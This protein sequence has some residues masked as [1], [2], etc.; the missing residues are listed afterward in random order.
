MQV[1]TIEGGGGLRLHVR[2]WGDPQGAAILLVHGWSQSHMSW[3]HQFDSTLA[4]EFRLVALDLRGHGM[5]EKPPEA[6]HYTDERLWAD[7]IAAVTGGLSLDRPVLVGW[8]Y[9]FIVSDYVRAHGEGS[10]SGINYVDAAVMLTEAFDH[11]GPGFLENAQ[12]A[13]AEDLPTNIAAMRRFLRACTAEPLGAEEREKA[14]CYNMVVSS[15]VRGAMI[16]RRLDSD[17]VL[18]RMTLPVLMTHG[19]EDAV[20]LPSMGRHILDVCPTAEAS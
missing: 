1:H 10:I 20:V 15:R 6:E 4:D 5:S 12:D 13:S 7:D 16:S 9:G 18:S 3:E 14:L 11:I 2:E 8:S 17:D 19:T